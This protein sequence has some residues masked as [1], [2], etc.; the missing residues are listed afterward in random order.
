MLNNNKT[1]E[2]SNL[3]DIEKT[4]NEGVCYVYEANERELTSFKGKFYFAIESVGL[5]HYFQAQNNNIG[6]DRMIGVPLNDLIDTQD[7]VKIDDVFYRIVRIQYK[8]YN[9]PHYISIS[10]Q[11]SP[12]NFVDNLGVVDEND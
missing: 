4:F 8:D 12:F 11:R 7:I 1:Y 5:N 9:R 6:I 10:L 3:R 2:N